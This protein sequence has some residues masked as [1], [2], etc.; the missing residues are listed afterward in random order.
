MGM[1]NMGGGHNVQNYPVNSK[2][3]TQLCR[4]FENNGNCSMGE[5]C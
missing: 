1:Q 3:K 2:Y 4:H 5:T